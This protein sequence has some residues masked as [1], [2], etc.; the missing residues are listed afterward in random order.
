MKKSNYLTIQDLTVKIFSIALTIIF[1][2]LLTKEEFGYYSQVFLVVGLVS[3]L[4]SSALPMGLSYFYGQY[5]S[6]S[7]RQRLFK[8]FFLTFFSMSFV[9]TFLFILFNSYIS[10]IFQ[11]IWIKEYKWL[12]SGLIFFT[13]VN[14]YFKNFT[15]LT[16]R[17]GKYVKINFLA[18]VLMF[19][20]QI[21]N[22][23]T[24]NSAFLIFLFF[25]FAQVFIFLSLSTDL[26]KY[27][28][29]KSKQKLVTIEE[30][31]YILPISAVGL[32]GVINE[33]IDQ[34]MVSVMLNPL[35]MAELKVGSFRIPFISAITTA[36]VTVLIPVFSNLISEN[37]T[38]NIVAQ[39]KS[40]VKKTTVL[41]LPIFVFSLVFAHQ[42]IG[43]LFS[44]K[45]EHAALIF[46]IYT[47]KYF[48]TVIT[49]G[50]VMGAIGL[51]KQWMYN[52]FTIVV[53]NIVLNYFAI[54]HYGIFGAATVTALVWYIGAALQ[55]YQINKRL[56]CSFWDYFPYIKYLKVLSLSLLVSMTLY[57]VFQ[58]LSLAFIWVV[59]TGIVFYV[60]MV[61]VFDRKFEYIRKGIV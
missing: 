36:T 53:L 61:Y 26:I 56:N 46:Q 39:W 55:I 20:L 7:K 9:L 49:F 50:A 11:N 51:Q 18:F 19:V 38:K 31:K 14:G 13:I 1:A 35:A 43:L 22:M 21:L 16:N 4:V 47:L 28:K 44:D 23:I 54:L 6:Y 45:Y 25:T 2:R 41:L 32:I 24:I 52:L 17:L 12:I 34:F 59:P 48:L 42:I 37:K 30:F 57:I 40:A 29:V 8:R 58:Y 60:F 33:L 27:L 15:L 5:K 10:N 3:A